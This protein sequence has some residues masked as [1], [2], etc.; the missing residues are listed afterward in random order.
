MKYLSVLF[1]YCF[2][3]FSCKTSQIK[4][5][6]EHSSIVMEKTACYGTCPV[7]R[8]SLSGSGKAIYEGKKYVEKTG[9]FEKQLSAQQTQKIFSTF[10]ASN[11]TDFRSEYTEPVT[12]LPTTYLTFSHRG[13][14]K[15]VKDYYN[16]P[17]ELK[18]LEKLV[19]EVANS[20]G[21]TEVRQ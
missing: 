20:E 4:N 7:Y 1:A 19:E 15:T 13:F 3:L 12:D 2:C 6:Y 21:W 5:K 11:F 8:I 9:K 17:A 18:K 10:E 14:S 16:A